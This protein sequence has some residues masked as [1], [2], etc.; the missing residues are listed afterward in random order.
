MEQNNCSPAREQVPVETSSCYLLTCKYRASQGL[1]KVS[2][3]FILRVCLPVFRDT[4]MPGCV[5]V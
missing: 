5:D 4:N 3:V 1:C 2:E